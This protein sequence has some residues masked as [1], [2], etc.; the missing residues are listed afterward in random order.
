MVA[1]LVLACVSIDKIAEV[2]SVYLVLHFEVFRQFGSCLDDSA[3]DILGEVSFQSGVEIFDDRFSL[4]S[5]VCK[6]L[7]AS[8]AF[9]RLQRHQAFDRSL[10]LVIRLCLDVV[11]PLLSSSCL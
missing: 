2:F 5:C 9:V 10:Q 3:L 8:G 1:F 7:S 11:A 4:F 6:E